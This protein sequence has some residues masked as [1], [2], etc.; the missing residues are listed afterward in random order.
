MIS[1]T[2]HDWSFSTYVHNHLAIPKIY[3][4][5]Q[6][7]LI[8]LPMEKAMH[9]DIHDGIDYVLED[10]NKRRIAVQERF[11][12]NNY[13]KYGDAT[14]RFRRE[15]NADPNR[16]KS[17]FYKIKADYLIYGICNGSKLFNKRNTLT[18]LSKWVALDIKFIQRKLGEGVIK[19]VSSSEKRFCWIKDEILYCPENHNPDKSSSFIPFDIQKIHSLWGRVPIIAQKGFL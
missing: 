17:E 13:V 5:L 16:I 9:L 18:D 7:N 19:I 4:L 6:W 15:F 3:N 14:L 10:A 2:D 1:K 8:S 11:R 12:D